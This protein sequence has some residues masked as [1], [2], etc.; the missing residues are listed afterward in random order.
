MR[1]R[2]TFLQGA[3]I[4]AVTAALVKVLGAIYKI[5][6]GNLLG[7]DGFAHFS[8][9]YHIYTLLLTASVAGLPTA[10]SRLIAKADTEGS[11]A[12]M[13]SLF[14]S[15]R[16][17]F[18]VL[19]ILA[20][21]VMWFGAEQLS[22]WMGDADAALSIKALAPSIVL[23]CLMS[24]Y[25]GYSQG[26]SD[27]IPTSVTQVIETLGKLII[28]MTAVWWLTS[29]G[30][31]LPEASAGA[32]F[33]VTFGSV[34]AFLYMV[35]KVKP[36][37]KTEGKRRSSLGRLLTIGIPITLAACVLSILAVVDDK[38]VLNGLQSIGVY[39]TEQVMER[40]GAFSKVQ[41]L[42]NIPSSFI[43]PLTISVIPAIVS[44]LTSGNKSAAKS[45]TETAL[46][47][48]FL[49][50]LPA[51][52]GLS[53]LSTQIVNVI[54]PQIHYEA[55]TLLMIL[56]IASFFSCLTLVT[57]AVLQAYG[58]E[59]VPMIT[60]LFGGVTNAAITYFTTPILDI[61]G[62]AIATIAGYVV[63][64]ALNL[65]ILRIKADFHIPASFLKL[66]FASA[67]MGAAAYF[68]YYAIERVIPRTIIALGGAI[69]LAVIVY[70]AL[71]LAL[72]IITRQ[73]LSFIPKGE[74]FAKILRL[75]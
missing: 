8:V 67:V 51:G 52:V 3:A 47:L 33:G 17:A 22:V 50:G 18:L 56:G 29:N 12:E 58:Y 31:G 49:L 65:V 41:T 35:I 4:L 6:L 32:I 75:K 16:N 26:L 62:V 55:A 71:V 34:I 42:F 23:V 43:V 2:Q 63:I 59:R 45:V 72:K 1:K 28:G 27:M 44:R 19:G 73:D 64:C 61:R 36:P 66:L 54:Y 37:Q 21:T 46:K 24:A 60:M 10:L 11:N 39:T 74:K 69:I 25:R 48:T 40:Y 14:C 13:R 38:L 5:P 30:Y 68:G 9:S 20:T 53:V 15:A 70:C 7:D 57:N